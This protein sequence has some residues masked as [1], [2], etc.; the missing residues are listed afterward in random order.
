MTELEHAVFL[1]YASQDAD[2]ALKICES[3][4][5]AGIEVWLDQSEL[6][7]GD[8]WDAAIRKQIKTCALFLP[9]ISANSTARSEGYFRLEWKLA[10]DRS[11]MMAAERT[12]ILPVVIDGVREADALVPDRFRDVQWTLCP[13][14]QAS[15]EFVA[16]VAAL[17][18]PDAAQ[19][20]AT[21][22]VPAKPGV[23]PARRPAAARAALGIAAAVVIA[24]LVVYWTAFRSQ[25]I[26]MVAVLPFENA[27]GDPANDYLSNGISES[28]INK[29]SGLS[30]LRVI[31]RTSAFEFKGKSMELT[32]IGKKLG[33]D[34]LVVGNLT[35]HGSRL[36]ISTELVRA[37]DS[38]QLWGDHYERVM[39]DVQQLEGQI[40]TTIAQTL[41]RR[42]SGEDEARLAHNETSDPEAYRLYLKGRE[43]LVG[44]DAEMDKSVDF[45]QQAV[46]RAPDYAMAYAGLADVYSAEAF[47]GAAGRT[48]AARKARAAATRALELAPDLGEAHAA[49]AGILFLFEWDWAGADAEFRRAIALSPGS[50]A[51]HEAYGSFLN[52]MGRL[53]EGLAESSE[54]AR[55]D[56]LSVQPFHDVA[57]NALIRRDFDKAAAGFRRT[58]E[59]DP[60]WTW[61]YIKLARTLALQGKCQEAFVEAETAERR[62]VGGVGALSRSW[63][64]STY[65]TCGD[66][67]RARG[68]L[69]ELHSFEAARYVDP[70]T[71]ADIH[72]SLGE[73]DEAVTWYRKAFADRSPDMVYAKAGSRL[74]PRLAA[75]AGF[76]EILDRMAFPASASQAN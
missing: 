14:G 2:A 59:I 52:A 23:V 16:R 71:F 56:P 51:V 60:H 53:D 75:N 61:G 3:L 21:A 40:A 33:V 6:R 35:L 7:G 15:A 46:Q 65:A 11:H 26:G 73:I 64:G 41:R 22:Q 42:L 69:A 43:F 9:V 5:A 28:L 63:L 72:A 54:A 1:S 44:T 37:R 74:N 10:V 39:D 70:E 30:G 55:L 66:V 20:A 24:G 31:S 47:L 36:N 49:L 48:E 13:A 12:F 34:A 38:T 29:L 58:I 57:I 32:D 25:A 17:L 76:R 4:R 18:S 19:P 27:T 45:F 67:A 50:E 8:A 68:K 62:I